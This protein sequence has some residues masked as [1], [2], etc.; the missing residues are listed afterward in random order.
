MSRVK[1]EEVIGLQ[2]GRLRKQAGMSQ[3]HLANQLAPHLEKPWSRQAVNMAERGK[4]AFS[5]A[6]LAALAVALGT[7]IVTLFMPWPGDTET[8]ELQVGSVSA[9][10][11]A[12]LVRSGQSVASQEVERATALLNETIAA[13]GAALKVLQRAGRKE[14]RD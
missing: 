1:I 2:I 4:R 7:D 8:V 5:A 14:D 6:E 12:V 9:Q 10:D 11:Y 13:S 3:A